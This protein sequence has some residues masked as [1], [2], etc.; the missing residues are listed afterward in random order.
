MITDLVIERSELDIPGFPKACA[1]NGILQSAKYLKNALEKDNILEEAL[2]RVE[3]NLIA[4]QE[5]CV[6]T[7]PI[8]R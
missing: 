3:V 4:S 8:E 2:S 7:K 6:E 5:Y 1:H